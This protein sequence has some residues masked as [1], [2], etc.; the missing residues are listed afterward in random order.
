MCRK[1]N[2]QG[3]ETD[4]G[5]VLQGVGRYEYTYDDGRLSGIVVVEPGRAPSGEY[6]EVEWLVSA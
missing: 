2:K 4:S 5:A 6:L 3:A 1:L